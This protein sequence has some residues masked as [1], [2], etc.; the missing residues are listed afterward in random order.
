MASQSSLL[1]CFCSV[2]SNRLWI[3]QLDG[4]FILDFAGATSLQEAFEGFC[5]STSFLTGKPQ[6]SYLAPCSTS[7]LAFMNQSLSPM[8]ESF[9]LSWDGRKVSVLSVR[10]LLFE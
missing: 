4:E 6:A 2:L 1:S 5:T 10:P 9:A 3:A 7:L 8:N